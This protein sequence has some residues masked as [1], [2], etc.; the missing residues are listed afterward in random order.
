MEERAATID[1]SDDALLAELRQGQEAAFERLVRSHGGPL[2]A[3]ARRI[4]GHEEDAREA[5]QD[6]FL[7]A[8]KAL[9]DFNGESRLSTWLHRI[10]VNAALQKLRRRQRKPERLIDDLLPR[11]GDDGHALEPADTW[12]EPSEAIVQRQETRALVR[13]AIEQLPE[14]YR[15]ILVLRDLEGLDTEEAAQ[16]LDVTIPVVK[17]RLHRARQ[18]LRTLLD[19]HLRGG[20]L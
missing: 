8:F 13:Q 18:A 12:N 15:T 2:L 6:A 20:A 5:V 16:A 4:V 1:R 3:T 7:S 11:F 10:V 14:Q 9:G 17:T 19:P